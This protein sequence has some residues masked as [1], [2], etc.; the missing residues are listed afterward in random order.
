[1][2]RKDIDAL[3]LAVRRRDEVIRI[4]QHIAEKS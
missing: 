4:H 3:V 2:R 1:M